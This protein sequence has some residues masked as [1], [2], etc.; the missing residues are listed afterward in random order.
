MSNAYP[1]NDFVHAVLVVISQARDEDDIISKVRA[2][3]IR[4]AAETGWRKNEMYLADPEVGFGSTLLH[5]EPDNSLFVCVDSWLPGRGVPPHE[6]GT[7]AVVVGVTGV[8]V[9]TFWER[10]DDGSVEGYAELRKLNE[11]SITAGEAICMKSGA[12]HS[13][14]NATDEITLS[15]HVYGHHLNHTGRSQFDVETNREMPFL[16]ETR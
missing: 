14:K 15:F 6:H 8:E 12:I 10:I 16:I 9:N 3:A 1:I 4:A 2:M 13:V 11:E 7:W 5:A